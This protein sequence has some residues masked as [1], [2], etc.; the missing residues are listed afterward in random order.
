[1]MM[2]TR[3]LPKR[4]GVCFSSARGLNSFFSRRKAKAKSVFVEDEAIQHNEQ[5]D[6]SIDEAE[7]EEEVMDQ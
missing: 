3:I 5:D 4:N 7:R 1:M 6:Q 2:M